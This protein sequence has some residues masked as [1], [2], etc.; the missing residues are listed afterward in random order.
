MA[1]ISKESGQEELHVVVYDN[2][3]ET[4]DRF[5]AVV[6]R[7]VKDPDSSFGVRQKQSLYRRRRRLAK[8]LNI[9]GLSQ[10]DKL[11]IRAVLDNDSQEFS[12][13]LES[14]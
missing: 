7:M 5:F 11:L 8:G 6:G 4:R 9:R 12:F 3:E 10:E 2:S 13:E 1:V 14:E